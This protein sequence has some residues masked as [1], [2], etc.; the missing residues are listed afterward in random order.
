[1]FSVK[2]PS[3]LTRQQGWRTC[4]TRHSL[5]SQFYFISFVQPT[6]LYAIMQNTCIRTYLTALRRSINYRCFQIT[7]RVKNFYTNRER[8]E[9]LTGYLSLGRRP[10]GDWA[11][12]WH[13]TKRSTVFFSNRNS[14]RA[15]YC[16]I[17]F[18][19]AFLEETFISN[20]IIILCINDNNAVIN[21]N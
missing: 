16:H 20:I 15:S 5:L 12:T 7:L 8:C 14:S 1:M 19:D 10:G 17:F 21:S 9:M 13:W 18:L 11:N 2:L 4:S 6:S 3:L